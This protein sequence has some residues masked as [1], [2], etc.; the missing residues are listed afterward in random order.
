MVT[1][2]RTPP[3]TTNHVSVR[4]RPQ[5]KTSARAPFVLKEREN[6]PL[7]P[8]ILKKSVVSS[9]GL[10]T[11]VAGRLT[12]AGLLALVLL[13]IATPAAFLKASRKLP[14]LKSAKHLPAERQL[15]S[16]PQG[17]VS[18]VDGR[19]ET[20][21]VPLT[22]DLQ[23]SFYALQYT[24]SQGILLA[25]SQQGWTDVRDRFIDAV[26]T[27]KAKEDERD[28]PAAKLRLW[29]AMD[30]AC[31]ENEVVLAQAFI[32]GLPTETSSGENALHS[33]YE[34][35]MKARRN[36]CVAADLWEARVKAGELG[37]DKKLQDKICNV[38]AAVR[39]RAAASEYFTRVL[40]H[41]HESLREGD[42]VVRRL[43]AEANRAYEAVASL[44][45]AGQLAATD[46]LILQEV[47]SWL[48][49]IFITI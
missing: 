44:D 46:P 12:A 20:P 11:G 24:K 33:A 22:V 42:V 39:S 37:E 17:D 9:L 25:A 28:E 16:S 49:I 41:A 31:L 34:A 2:Q 5:V 1:P 35:K 32:D 36:Q 43:Y 27:V 13:A 29:L 48:P 40:M 47:A 4:V 19:Q 18:V 3:S 8:S 14:L 21:R 23:A 10:G 15:D 7:R 38:L 6:I 30:F 45:I 26:T